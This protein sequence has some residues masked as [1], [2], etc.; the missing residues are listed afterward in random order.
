M[1]KGSINSIES[2]STMD[3]PGIRAVIFLNKCNLR[4]KYCHNPETWQMK[5]YN[6]TP[7]ELVKK[8]I[9][10]KPYFKN[11]GGITF[12]GGEPLCQKEFLIDTCKLLKKK[13]FI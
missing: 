3:G 12:S 10:Y 2:F 7:E 11:N 8:L 9:K 4:C 6:Y 1:I 5:D 13:I